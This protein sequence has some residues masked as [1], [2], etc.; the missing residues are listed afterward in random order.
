VA[1]VW[2]TG[3]SP[4]EYAVAEGLVP[5]QR[6]FLDLLLRH[7]PPE[8][9]INSTCDQ[10]FDLLSLLIERY[11]KEHPNGAEVF[12]KFEGLFYSTIDR[13]K[14]HPVQEV[15]LQRTDTHTVVSS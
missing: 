9:S 5:P 14:N 7:I 3:C 4:D 13:I 12:S 1:S 10:F 8:G 11:F 2:C 6:F 15:H